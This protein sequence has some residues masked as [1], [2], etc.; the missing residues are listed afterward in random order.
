MTPRIALSAASERTATPAISTLMGMALSDPG[1]VSLAAGFVDQA[2]LPVGP[3]AREFSALADD[4]AE[5]RRALQYGLTAGDLALRSRLVGLLESSEGVEAGSFAH[6]L[7]RTVVTTGSQQLLYL[8]AE[9]LLDPGDIVLVESPTYFVFLGVLESRG[10]RAIGVETDGHGLRL[11]SLEGTLARL[12]SE[13]SIERV[14]LIY[15]VSE[16]SNPSGISL[17][18]DRRGPLVGL[19]RKWSRRHRIFV[20][21]DSAY[22]GLTYDGVEP[23]SVWQHDPEG[24]TVILARTFSKTF[25]PGLKTGYG[26]LPE[27]LVDPVQRL[28]GNHDFGSANFNQVLIERLIAD[29]SYGRQVATLVDRYR[30]KRDV[31]LDAIEEHLGPFDGVTWTHPAGGLYVWL[32]LPE[33]FDTGLTGAFFRGC[34]R[35]SVLY[36]PGAFAFAGEPGPA[37]KNHARLCFGVAGEVELADGVRRLAKA[38][39]GCLDP[40]A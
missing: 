8:V 23:P 28:K 40:V 34:V 26:V 1:M 10:A 38:L 27:A 2:T 33:G 20:L 18:D 25:S 15:T 16:H 19:A 37:P 12:E 4:P 3:T 21:E 32:S 11:D 24:D 31:L 29:G 22:R 17:G 6:V 13:G 7:P 30:R 35:E 9:A 5:A 39:A 14:K 36:V